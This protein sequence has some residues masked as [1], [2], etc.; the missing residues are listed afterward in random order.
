MLREG[1]RLGAIIFGGI[2]GILY[3]MKMF[4]KM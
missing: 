4:L 1:I 3:T 2:S